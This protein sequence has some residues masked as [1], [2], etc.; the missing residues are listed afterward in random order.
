MKNR[1]VEVNGIVKR[2]LFNHWASWR[3][4]LQNSD[5][6]NKSRSEFKQLSLEMKKFLSR[7]NRM[8]MT[9][10]ILITGENGRSDSDFIFRKSKAKGTS[11]V[12]MK[13]PLR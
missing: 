12:L 9:L 2:V 6:I 1:N 3:T 5:N 7:N 4:V 13:I 8:R 11:S 10:R